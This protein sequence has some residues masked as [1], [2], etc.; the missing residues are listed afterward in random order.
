MFT[1][2]KGQLV[3]SQLRNEVGVWL[4]KGR[5][6]GAIGAASRGAFPMLFSLIYHHFP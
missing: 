4:I 3:A 1:V 2:G 6:Q 5:I